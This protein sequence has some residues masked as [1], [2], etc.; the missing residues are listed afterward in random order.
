MSKITMTDE[1]ATPTT[2]AAG[3]TLLYTQGGVLRVLNPSGTPVV[4]ITTASLGTT[5]AMLY[6]SAPGVPAGVSIGTAGQFLAV[7]SGATAPVWKSPPTFVAGPTGS[8]AQY[9]GAG[10]TPIADA[11]AAA[12]GAGGGVVQILP[13]LYSGVSLTLPSNVSLVG[14]GT[15]SI[16]ADVTCTATSGFTFIQ[17]LYIQGSLTCNAGASSSAEVILRNASIRTSSGAVSPLTIS[18]DGWTVFLVGCLVAT[19][20]VGLDAVRGPVSPASVSMDAESTSF[21]SD[22]GSSFTFNGSISQLNLNG[23]Y[24]SNPLR[25]S[26]AAGAGV[27]VRDCT[28]NFAPATPSYVFNFAGAGASTLGISGSFS[29]DSLDNLTGVLYTTG[30]TVSALA[31]QGSFLGVYATANLPALSGNDGALAYS[32]DANS[33]Y[34]RRLG[35]WSPIPS[36]V[37]SNT[38]N[39]GGGTQT[40]YS[41]Q[42]NRAAIQDAVNGGVSYALTANSAPL[43][44][45]EIAGA[46]KSVSLFAP[47]VADVGKQWT[48]YDAAR[49]AG[50]LGVITITPNGTDTINGVNAPV[51][52]T[53]NG[54]SQI[55]RVSGAN[56]WETI[57][58]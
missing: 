43:V 47:L 7:N 29:L 11:I 27:Y 34:V 50:G 49:D 58:S 42:F 25:T 8:A 44:R 45:M 54:G 21:I 28:F 17:D 16:S 2:P 26:T 18:N 33:L 3:T 4:P 31:T 51:T 38:W 12:S 19:T 1:G 32:S 22:N 53:T 35:G 39:S 14:L 6:A 20:V 24:L 40:F 55:F 9:T 15:A 13:G 10:L 30:G 46:P 36:S 5:G 41:T 57:G 48:I 23:C 37:A 56:A 52:I